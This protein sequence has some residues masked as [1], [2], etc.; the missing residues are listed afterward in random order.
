MLDY[1]LD[2]TE[3]VVF[4]ER[5]RYLQAHLGLQ[6]FERLADILFDNK[7]E[8]KVALQF[9]KKGKMPVVEG[10][11]TGQISLICQSCLEALDWSI[12]QSIKI[13]MVQTIEQA[14]CLADEF[15]PFIVANEKI[16]L[17]RLIEDEV[18]IC[19]PDYPRHTHEC[20]QYQ[21]AVKLVESNIIQ[22]QKSANP[23]AALAKLKMTGDQ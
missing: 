6:C 14:N 8:I 16:L 3:S 22:Q 13:A 5:Q 7:G 12:D 20:L 19:L 2:L 1:L 15:E 17:S 9:Y 21:P 23:F 11:I 10:H 18:L 4:S